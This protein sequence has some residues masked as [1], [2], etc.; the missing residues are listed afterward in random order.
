MIT[1]IITW[2]P[3]I[4]TECGKM[5]SNDL[6]IMSLPQYH[7][8]QSANLELEK[9]C[10]MFHYFITLWILMDGYC[11]YCIQNN[12]LQANPI[13]IFAFMVWKCLNEHSF[14][15]FRNNNSWP[16][17]YSTSHNWPPCDVI[18]IVTLCQDEN[19]EILPPRPANSRGIVHV[20]R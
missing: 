20:Q 15:H 10:F 9:F 5:V 17:R 13:R 2:S 4:M 6:M 3:A 19:H 12:I 11:C 7:S 16:S 8:S 14:K 18:V 1:V